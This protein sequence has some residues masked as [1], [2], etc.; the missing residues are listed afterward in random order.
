M[1]SVPCDLA[2]CEVRLPYNSPSLSGTASNILDEGIFFSCNWLYQPA[3]G[4]DNSQDIEFDFVCQTHSIRWYIDAVD[5]SLSYFH[6]QNCR[7]WKRAESRG[8]FLVVDCPIRPSPG[9]GAS[10]RAVYQPEPIAESIDRLMAPWNPHLQSFVS[11]ANWRKCQRSRLLPP[12]AATLV[13]L[14]LR[15]SQ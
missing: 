7:M 2:Q 8:H 9:F 14:L 15:I 5:Y 3:F 10:A 11:R 12:L 1:F 4:E 6:R 13:S